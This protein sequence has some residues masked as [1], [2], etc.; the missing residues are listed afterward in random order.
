MLDRIAA[1]D[2]SGWVRGGID[3]ATERPFSSL[4]NAQVLAT[5]LRD[6]VGAVGWMAMTCWAR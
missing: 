5:A 3:G 4:A 6:L 2:P 1:C